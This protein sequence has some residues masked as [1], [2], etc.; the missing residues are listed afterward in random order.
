MSDIA[1]FPYTAA[2]RDSVVKLAIEAWSGILDGTADE[3]PRFAYDA[4][5]PDGWKVRQKADVR[6]FL[7]SEPHHVWL[8]F[9][10]QVLVGF[11]GIRL[12]SEDRMGEIYIIAVAPGHRRSGVARQ[13]MQVA[14]QHI[15]S[16]GMEMIM[17]ETIG[18]SG[19]APAR[20]AY[21]A[22]GFEPWPVA[23]YFKKIQ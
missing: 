18:D 11:V 13:L 10:K 12:H 1:I 6:A 5:Y 4:F 17:V 7:A 23:R 14:Q 15:Q 2:D 16:A 8:A 9:R 3:V 20:R 19:H 21:E 22:F